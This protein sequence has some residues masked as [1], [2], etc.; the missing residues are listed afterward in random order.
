MSLLL[1]NDIE[2]ILY[3]ISYDT[4]I[5]R[6]KYIEKV[7]TEYS[8]HGWIYIN[9]LSDVVWMKRVERVVSRPSLYFV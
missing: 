6:A 5:T 4:T 3:T 1:Q 7:T 2:N 9:Y 8:T